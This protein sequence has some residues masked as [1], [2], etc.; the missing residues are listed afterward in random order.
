LS[1]ADPYDTSTREGAE[2]HLREPAGSRNFFVRRDL[3]K[4]FG[5]RSKPYAPPGDIDLSEIY[6]NEFKAFSP[7]GSFRL[8]G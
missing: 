4:I 6:E 1:P 3:R 5:Y 2:V 8:S 7:P